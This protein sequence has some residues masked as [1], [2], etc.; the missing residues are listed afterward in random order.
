MIPSLKP[1]AQ[2]EHT[3]PASRNPSW[4]EK[5]RL[6]LRM[7]RS[8]SSRLNTNPIPETTLR[9]TGAGQ[10]G[11]RRSGAVPGNSQEGVKR[12]TAFLT[13]LPEDMEGSTPAEGK[14]V[15]ASHPHRQQIEH[16]KKNLEL[17][18][19]RGPS[20]SDFSRGARQ[21]VLRQCELARLFDES[22]SPKHSLSG[23]PGPREGLIKS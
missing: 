16:L 8:P 21:E 9:P 15:P 5:I 2:A 4:T 3:L 18:S 22:K 19:Q 6:K 11:G 20:A 1:K 17:I 7:G 12:D 13:L 14:G 23:S 10:P